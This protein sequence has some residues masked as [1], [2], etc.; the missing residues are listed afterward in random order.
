MAQ[1]A[2]HIA[3]FDSNFTAH[4]RGPVPLL[5]GRRGLHDVAAAHS[6][7]H[8][9]PRGLPRRAAPTCRCSAC[10]ARPLT[11]SA[12]G[13]HAR[14]SGR[15][16]SV[17]VALR[18]RSRPRF[19]PTRYDYDLDELAGVLSGASADVQDVSFDQPPAPATIL[20]GGPDA[21][22]A[23]PLRARRRRA[24]VRGTLVTAGRHQPPTCSRCCP[25]SYAGATRR[26][27]ATRSPR[28]SCD[29]LRPLPAALGVRRAAVRHHA[30]HRDLPR[31]PLRR[32]RRLQA[33]RRERRL[34]AR[35]GAD[36]ADL[37]T[38]TAILAAA[39]T[40]LA[41]YTAVRAQYA[42]SVL[43]RWFV[44]DG[45]AGWHSFVGAQPQYLARLYP[46]DAAANGGF[47]RP[48]SEI[49]GAWAFA[50][51]GRALL[52]PSRPGAHRTGRRARL[53]GCRLSWPPPTP[54]ASSATA[55][56]PAPRRARPGCSSTRARRRRSPSTRPSS[57]PSPAS[58]GSRCAGLLLADPK[59][60][61]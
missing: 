13:D 52:R 50:D 17:D 45:T 60:G 47:V 8:R 37:V 35:A 25:P 20:V 32:A 31:E 34:A 40:I 3:L 29:I 58:R 23:H 4:R 10:S 7:V 55:R 49:G 41:L 16:P 30:R 57:T 21:A 33:G 28:R 46:A 38:P 51:A 39:N 26:P 42:E 48:S 56:S 5:R 2:A 54:A 27:C 36:D 61:S 15:L 53:R 22:G 24:P 44:H 14:R 9:G 59:L 43:D 6:R 12:T 11:V 19:E 18:E 1:G